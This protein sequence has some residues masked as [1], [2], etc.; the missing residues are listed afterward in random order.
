MD[1]RHKQLNR[2]RFGAAAADYVTSAVHARG[3]SLDRLLELAD[4]QPGWRMLDVATGG[5]H[6]AL[7]F[8][9]Q[10]RHV[11][12]LDLT[13]PMLLAARQHAREREAEQLAY[14]QAD[15]E[16]LPFGGSAFD[17]VTCRIAS[18]HFANVAAFVRE[19]ARV[20]APGGVF[21]LSDNVT[22]GEPKVAQ[23]LNTFERFRDPSHNWAYNVED[24]QSFFVSAGLVVVHS[25]TF[26]K[27]IDFDEW[28][29]R[30][31]IAG[32]HLMRLRV[33]LLQAPAG[34][35]QW[36]KPRRAGSRLLFS[37]TEGI[38]IGRK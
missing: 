29:A 11:V 15:A 17:C 1:D 3:Y 24:W 33:L 32:D 12:A 7:A 19:V 26:Q 31:S 13:H 2:Q 18:H 8:A 14:C 16:R 37:I 25:E 27:E 35:R 9:P 22:G 6:T 30:T 20:L 28:A 23:Y 4:P 34:V 21:A 5:G 38:V 10:V 36:L